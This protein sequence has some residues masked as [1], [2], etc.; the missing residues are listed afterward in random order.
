MWQRQIHSA[1][2]FGK[3]SI[4]AAGC[5]SWTMTMSYSES[6]NSSALISL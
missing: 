4:I 6:S 3:W 2:E 1:S 5:G